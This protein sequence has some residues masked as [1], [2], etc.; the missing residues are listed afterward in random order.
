MVYVLLKEPKTV[1]GKNQSSSNFRAGDMTVD[2]ERKE[3]TEVLMMNGKGPLYRYLVD[4]Y[5]H[6]SFSKSQVRARL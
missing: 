1:L 3:I 4:D 6:V 2:P 5:K